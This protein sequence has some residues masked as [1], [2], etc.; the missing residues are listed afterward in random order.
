MLFGASATAGAMTQMMVG[1]LD[2]SWCIALVPVDAARPRHS[3]AG[4]GA[5]EWQPQKRMP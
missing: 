1:K 4:G 2:A 5:P 3:G